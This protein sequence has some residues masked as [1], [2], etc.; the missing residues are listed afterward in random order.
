MKPNLLFDTNVPKEIQP[1]RNMLEQ[2]QQQGLKEI[3]TK[4]QK[5]KEDIRFEQN[6]AMFEFLYSL[7][8][9]KKEKKKS[10]EAVRK[11]RDETWKKAM[12]EANNNEEEAI[13]I[14]DELISF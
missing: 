6:L 4:L 1:I 10:T 11:L 8:L 14:Y 7:T 5:F 12:K 9:S 13:K 3:D 2:I